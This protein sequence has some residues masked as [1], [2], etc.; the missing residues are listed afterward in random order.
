MNPEKSVE[1]PPKTNNKPIDPAKLDSILADCIKKTVAKL[2][3]I[4]PHSKAK[5]I[6]RV[7]GTRY[8]SFWMEVPDYRDKIVWDE[9]E[10]IWPETATELINYLWDCGKPRKTL[11]GRNPDKMSWGRF[12]F[13]ELVHDPILGMLEDSVIEQLI[14]GDS[15]ES[16]VITDEQI[17]TPVSKS[18]QRLSEGTTTVVAFCPLRGVN[19]K[20][21][22]AIQLTEN[23]A[24]R[25]YTRIERCVLLS[26]HSSA[27]L[28]DDFVSPTFADVIAEF[29]YTFRKETLS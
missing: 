13:G 23:V 11:S 19:L 21:I 29:S 22:G 10:K 24:L 12:V 26:K 5:I 4:T 15:V 25:N 28:W 2:S 16:W 7:Q 9:I 17:K 1:L 3:S 18:V 20:D 8:G 6:Y 14:D 27:F